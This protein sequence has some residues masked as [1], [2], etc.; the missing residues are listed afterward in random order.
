[1]YKVLKRTCFAFELFA[2][3]GVPARRVTLPWD[4]YM[5]NCHPGWQGYPTWQTG[6][7]AQAGHPSH[8]SC[9]RDQDKLRNYMDRRVTPL[10]RAT[11]PTWGTHGVPNLHVNRPLA[12]LCKRIKWNHQ[13][14][15]GL[16]KGNHDG[17]LVKFHL[18]LNVALLSYAEVNLR[19]CKRW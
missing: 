2:M 7:P 1:M 5:T 11:S 12:V 17:K 13:N 10:R 4:V 15:C 8:L 3:N 16:V 19:R 18:E 14:L 9:K 6:Q